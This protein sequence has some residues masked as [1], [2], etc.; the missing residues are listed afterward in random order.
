MKSTGTITLRGNVHVQGDLTADHIIIED[1]ENSTVVIDDGIN[2]S[3]RSGITYYNKD[4]IEF[5]LKAGTNSTL[6]D[7]GLT[8]EIIVGYNVTVNS[9]LGISS[10]YNT[11]PSFLEGNIEEFVTDADRKSVV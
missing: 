5:I 6:V 1:T 8:E 10:N 7:E 2:I 11:V 3:C 4:G 9:K